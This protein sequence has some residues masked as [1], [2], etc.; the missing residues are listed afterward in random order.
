MEVMVTVERVDAEEM[1]ANQDGKVHDT[2]GDGRL[3]IRP[4]RL[5]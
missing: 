1:I 2:D 4:W 5:R 3:L